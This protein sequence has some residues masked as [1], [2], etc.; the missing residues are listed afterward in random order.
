MRVLFWS[1]IGVILIGAVMLWRYRKKPAVCLE[2]TIYGCL[3]GG[4][5][6]LLGCC[7]VW[8]S[9]RGL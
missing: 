4:S 7:M 9:F 3:S 8:L 6:I 2:E 5:F 1:G